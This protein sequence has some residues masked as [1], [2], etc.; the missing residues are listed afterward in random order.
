MTKLVLANSSY[1]NHTTS[2]GEQLQAGLAHA[3][4]SLAGWG[5]PD[6]A[7]HTITD[8]PSILGQ[9]RP[10]VVF[11]QDKR[12]WDRNNYG[13]SFGNRKLH[14]DRIEA[15][16]ARPDIFTVGVV[17]DAGSM[18]PYQ[19]AAIREIAAD[20]VVI[21][22]HERNVLRQSRWLS[23]FKLIR[24]YHS[25]DAEQCPPFDPSAI[26]KRAIVTGAANDRVYP[27]RSMAIGMAKRTKLD[28]MKH[29][30]YGAGGCHT[31][32][33]LRVLGGY[34]VHVATASAYGFAL[35][36]IIESVAM[37][38]TPVTNLPCWDCLP[39][40]D[41]ALV[42]IK[43]DADPDQLKEA[44]DRAESEWNPQRAWYFA[45]TA[46]KWYDFRAVGARLDRNILNAMGTR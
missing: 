41:D 35:R 44:V 5:Y 2:E 39:E 14:F 3:G 30:G 21:Y 7:E 12:D 45:D 28:V 1:V 23:E 4:W 19:E 18:V 34:K 32:N 13:G 31:P 26:R 37:G 38:C 27:L 43:D 33:Y 9:Y 10:D 36:K 25:V 42:R 29:P 22:Y 46:R 6:W 24:T 15:L 11:V 8:V 40:I 17:K 16:A 20:A